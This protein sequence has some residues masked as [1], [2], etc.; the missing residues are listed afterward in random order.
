MR[1]FLLMIMLM[2]ASLLHAQTVLKGRVVFEGTPPA[3]EAVEVQSDIPTC[4]NHKEVQKIIL[5]KDQGIANAVVK[6]VGAAGTPDPKKG[7]LDQVNCEFVPHVQAL[8]VGSTLVITSSDPVLHNSHGFLEDGSTAFNIAVPIAGMEVS[9]KLDQAGVIKLRC[10]A[11]HTWMSAYIVV[12]DQ[13]YYALTDSDG[14]F[15]IEGIPPGNYQIE[16]WQ[17]WLGKQSQ[18]VIVKEGAAEPVSITLK[19]QG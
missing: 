11:G 6:I 13:P 7:S 3:A 5:G 1:I 10:D 18:P 8:P 12:T 2:S 14:N 19:Q 9:K 16:V 4:G 17:E 15:T